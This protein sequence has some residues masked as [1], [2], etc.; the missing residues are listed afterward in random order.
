MASY[1][2]LL[3]GDG[4]V[5]KTTFAKRC[6]NFNDRERRYIAT[7]GAEVHPLEVTSPDGDS[8]TCQLWDLAGQEK[9]SSLRDSYFVQADAAII[10]V[11]LSKSLR[12]LMFG[13]K[14]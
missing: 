12:L 1:K 7:M 10:M 5:G 6:R 4:A 11:D 13:L 9:F 8:I 2:V 3:A 14:Q